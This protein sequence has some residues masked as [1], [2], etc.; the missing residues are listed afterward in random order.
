LI[1]P[2][3]TLFGLTP[4]FGNDIWLHAALAVIAAYFGFVHRD[5][6]AA[7]AG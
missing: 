4:L 5:S 7:P 2:L 6:T 1:P 3:D